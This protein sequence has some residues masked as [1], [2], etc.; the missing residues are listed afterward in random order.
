MKMKN[1]IPLLGGLAVLA[2]VISFG[3]AF[4]E[5]PV[6]GDAGLLARAK[7]EMRDSEFDPDSFRIAAKAEQGDSCLVW[8]SCGTEGSDQYVPMEFEITGNDEYRFVSRRLPLNRMVEIYELSWRDSYS[9]LIANDAC[10]YLCIDPAYSSETI[11]IEI[12]EQPFQ[13]CYEDDGS[14]D[15]RFL[16]AN[17]EELL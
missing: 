5:H 16:D 9:F 17:G 8:F 4:M 7:W 10:R 14:F 13:Y 1:T 11:R 3:L 12:E 15:C 6:G 2:A